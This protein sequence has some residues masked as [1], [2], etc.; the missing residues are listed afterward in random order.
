MRIYKLLYKDI[1]TYLYIYVFIYITEYN[2]I[3]KC[4]FLLCIFN[5]YKFLFMAHYFHRKIFFYLFTKEIKKLLNLIIP[6]LISSILI[7]ISKDVK[8]EFNSY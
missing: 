5:A 8:N 7:F 4:K 1:P 2:I 6:L 3:D